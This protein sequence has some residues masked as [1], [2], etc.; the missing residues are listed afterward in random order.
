MSA[1]I[2]HEVFSRYFEGAPVLLIPGVTH[3]V[4]DRFVTCQFPQNIGSACRYLED[5]IPMIGYLPD[6]V[7]SLDNKK[8]KLLDNLRPQYDDL[9]DQTLAAVHH[10]ASSKN[11]DYQV[12]SQAHRP[13]GSGLSVPKQ[14]IG[15]LVAYI[16]EKQHRAGI[17]IFL[18]GSSEIRRCI[19]MINTCLAPGLADIFPLHANLPIEEQNCVFKETAKWKIIAATNVAEVRTASWSVPSLTLSTNRPPLR[20]KISF[21]SL[22]LEKSRKHAI[23]RGRISQN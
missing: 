1:T 16:V 11:I 6:S 7:Q 8:M 9:D 15:S 3:P 13:V 5:I 4:T 18:P 17:L 12:G 20:S 10:I 14:L 2:N 19:D 23:H 21:M 22:M